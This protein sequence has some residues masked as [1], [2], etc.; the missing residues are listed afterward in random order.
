V[1][2]SVNGM[3]VPVLLHPTEERDVAWDLREMGSAWGR[4]VREGL[5]PQE[6]RKISSQCP[7][8][9]ETTW[10]RRGKGESGMMKRDQCEQSALFSKMKTL[11]LV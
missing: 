10:R 7:A 3:D 11:Q 2:G 8:R 6:T 9:T 1:N 4:G 5:A